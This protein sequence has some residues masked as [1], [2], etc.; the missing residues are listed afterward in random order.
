MKKQKLLK[1][2]NS[3]GRLLALLLTLTAGL[4]YCS[5]AWAKE[6]GFWS[7]GTGTIKVNY[8][9]YSDNWHDN[10]WACGT[11]S[12]GC[13]K[14]SAHT[15]NVGTVKELY[16]KEWW[17]KT[18]KRDCDIT[19]VDFQYEI[20]SSGTK[21]ENHN[22]CTDK[23]EGNQQWGNNDLAVDAR[24]YSGGTPGD[25]ELNY[26]FWGKMDGQDVYSNTNAYYHTL[27]FTVP[28]F[29][30]SS[31]T[32]VNLGEVDINGSGK[33]SSKIEFHHY[34]DT[35]GKNDCEFDGTGSGYYTI[36]SIDYSGVKVKYHPTA[37][38]QHNVTLTITN[39]YGDSHSTFTVNLKGSGVTAYT[40]TVLIAGKETVLDT[41]VTLNGYIKY[42]GCKNVTEYG[43]VYG[44]EATPTTSDTK[45]EAGTTGAVAGKEFSKEFSVTTN[46][47]YYY[48]AYMIAGG[49]TY[50]STE[51]R[52]FT[53]ESTCPYYPDPKPV[54]TLNGYVNNVICLD[55][56]V[57]AKCVSKPGFKYELYGPNGNII[58]TSEREGNGSTLVWQRDDA[59]KAAG[60]YIVKTKKEGTD[61]WAISAKATQ[62]INSATMTIEAENDNPYA[63]QPVIIKKS[64]DQDEFTKPTWEIKTAESGAYLLNFENKLI[65]SNKEVD[66]VLFKGGS[67]KEV[68]V[69]ANAYKTVVFEGGNKTC[70]A[71]V[72]PVT[73]TVKADD[74]HCDY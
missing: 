41:E 27:K 43:F 70:P 24:G 16:I 55:E 35:P 28:G 50:Y 48:R 31:A 14:G 67:P 60:Q 47:T 62:A 25:Y 33:T 45:I 42:T 58:G 51:V 12:D 7:D 11:S 2:L 22:Y 56:S 69:T 59:L 3:K 39:K 63:Y 30:K 46:G 17:A 1:H 5:S 66:K 74:E 72:T 9:D 37:G 34:G 15:F 68:Q 26:W 61:C 40:P 20:G 13:S 32:D 53:I 18:Y 29:N 57:V 8:K 19:D 73:I 49:T 6:Y 38:G 64:A 65:Y 23:G 54:L 4:L 44:T 36:E 52:Q 10:Q 21:S 71:V